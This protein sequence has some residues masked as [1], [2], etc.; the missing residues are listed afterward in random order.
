MKF[1]TREYYERWVVGD[2]AYLDGLNAAY[3]ARLRQLEEDG[4]T[5]LVELGRMRLTHDALLSRLSA[6]IDWTALQIV[7]RTGDALDGYEDIEVNYIGAHILREGRDA[8]RQVALATESAIIHPILLFR[9][10]V[11]IDS[12]RFVHRFMFDDLRSKEVYEVEILYR[13]VSWRIVPR[14]SRRL[15]SIDARYP[16]SQIPNLWEG[17]FRER[18]GF[19]R[20]FAFYTRQTTKHGLSKEPTR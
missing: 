9:T 1:F 20:G 2:H 6:S 19:L 16:Q 15:P 4:H 3:A 11:D 17:I 8:L 14:K 12:G 18:V 7:F 5:Q 10:E 13:V